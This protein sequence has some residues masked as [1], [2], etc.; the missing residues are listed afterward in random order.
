MHLKVFV[1]A[2]RFAPPRELLIT[3]S[4]NCNNKMAVIVMKIGH[5][6][7]ELASAVSI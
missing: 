2:H 3:C 4:T 5:V 1:G 7:G 6:T